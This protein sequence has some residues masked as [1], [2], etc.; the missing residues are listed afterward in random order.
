MQTDRGTRQRANFGG[1]SG[2]VRIPVWFTI[3]CGSGGP[4]KK[5]WVFNSKLRGLCM[6]LDL[7]NS[8]F[9]KPDYGHGFRPE[10]SG[11][12]VIPP[13]PLPLQQKPHHLLARVLA[14]NGCCFSKHLLRRRPSE[15][16]FLK[17]KKTSD[18]CNYRKSGARLPE[19]WPRCIAIPIKR[20]LDPFAFLKRGYLDGDGIN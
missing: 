13:A 11:S 12:S 18:I 2:R 3:H 4:R 10:L 8:P 5:Q 6:D 7:P 20:V 1:I 19:K 9:S 14:G 17:K 15:F 16:W